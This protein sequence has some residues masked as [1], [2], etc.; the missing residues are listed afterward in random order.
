[1]KREKE[2]KMKIGA[3]V[4]WEKWN[5]GERLWIEEK[6]ELRKIRNFMQS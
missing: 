3:E 6:K 2:R 1:M 5:E 4:K